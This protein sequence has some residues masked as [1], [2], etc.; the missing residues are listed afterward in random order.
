M[1]ELNTK[2]SIITPL[3][4]SEKFI[5]E[6]INS[7]INQTYNKWELL[8]IDDCSRDHSADIVKEFSERDERIKYFKTDFPSG[9]PTI[10]RNLGIKLATGR[11]IAFLDSDDLWNFEKLMKQLELFSS[12]DVAIVYSDYEKISEEGLSTNRFILA[13]EKVS[14]NDLLAGNIIA[15]STCMYDTK[16]VGKN[17]FL[18]QG[19]EDYAMWLSILKKGFIAK[20]C[21]YVSMKYRVRDNSISSNKFKAILW[22]WNIYRKNEGLNLLKSSYYSILTLSKSFSKYIK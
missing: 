3:Y 9:S 17:Y 21:N 7:V 22:V 11:Y 2:V 13:P 6:T 5:T 18:K 14:Y 8:V 4:N 15:C 10:P 16:K 12:I 19:H 1:N 20:N